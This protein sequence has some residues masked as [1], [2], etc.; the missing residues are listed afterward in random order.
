MP[1]EI[2]VGRLKEDFEKFGSEAT[3]YLGKHIVGKG[4]EAYLANKIMMDLLRPHLILICGKRGT[5]K[6]YFGGV[7]AEEIAMLPEKH[8]NNLTTVMIDT[9]GIYWSMKLPNEE[10]VVLLDQWGLKP[11]GLKD[12]V[13]VYVP[14]QQKKDYEDAGIPVDFGIS[15]PPHMFSAE[16]WSTA[17][18]LPQTNPLAIGLQKAVNSLQKRD[19][20]FSI[21]DLIYK[22]KDDTSIDTHTKSALESMLTVANS[23]GVFGDEGVKTEEIMKPG[24]INVFDVSRL[25]STE[26]WSVRNLLVALIAKDVYYKRVMARKQ[27]ELARVGEIKLK[28]RFPM[29]W[30]LIDEAHNFI[31]ADKETVSTAPLLTIVKQGR[32]PGVSL[33]PMT[34]MPNKIHPE[35]VSQADM[36]ISHRLTSKNDLDALHA[37]MQTYLMED[38]W[39]YIEGLPKWRGSSIILDDNS[40]R[41]FQMQTRPRLTWHAGESASAVS[42]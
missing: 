32:E 17:F 20:K 31:P 5:G 34:Q 36:I 24:M 26:A 21:D 27:E 1:N 3:A 30:M 6:S 2:V 22:I 35:V 25:R 40:E 14:F 33:V 37:S 4:D 12:R 42:T 39:K 10:Q 9:M 7:I 13:K 41:I 15:V 28:Q 19:E 29:V 18:N 38:V 16:E 23:W 11:T 8:R